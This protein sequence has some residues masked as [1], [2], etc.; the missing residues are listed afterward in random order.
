MRLRKPAN[1]ARR[2]AV[3]GMKGRRAVGGIGRA[4]RLSLLGAS[5]R[6]L[7]NPEPCLSP[8][9]AAP[10]P[11][12]YGKLW[13]STSCACSLGAALACRG[14][15]EG[16]Q[17][18][19][20]RADFAG[21]GTPRA[22]AWLNIPRRSASRSAIR[23]V[24]P[25]DG[26]HSCASSVWIG[27]PPVARRTP[28]RSVAQSQSATRAGALRQKRPPSL[29]RRPLRRVGREPLRG[30]RAVRERRPTRYELRVSNRGAP[31]PTAIVG[32]APNARRVPPSQPAPGSARMLRATVLS[33]RTWVASVS[34]RREC[35]RCFSDALEAAVFRP[36]GR[37]RPRRARS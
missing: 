14:D 12:R 19:S 21:T 36:R 29:P 16:P 28:A 26:A 10:S 35:F 30:P 37:R 9:A 22:G 33:A 3:P 32:A 27:K 17:R 4:A 15:E 13:L 20:A 18:A 25:F 5:S 24:A 34:R 11:S 1:F 8:P 2:R 23:A 31:W 7:I 6:R